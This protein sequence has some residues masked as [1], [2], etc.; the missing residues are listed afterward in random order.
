LLDNRTNRTNGG[1]KPS[2]SAGNYGCPKC[3]TRIE[4]HVRMSC[5]PL[6]TMHNGAVPMEFIKRV[7]ETIVETNNQEQEVTE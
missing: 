2:V 7:K 4:V 6:C 3:G 5:L 1:R